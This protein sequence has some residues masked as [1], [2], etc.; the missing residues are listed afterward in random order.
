MAVVLKV[1]P[2]IGSFNLEHYTEL[3]QTVWAGGA[4]D[5]EAGIGELQSRILACRWMTWEFLKLCMETFVVRTLAREFRAQNLPWQE[6]MP[7]EEQP[8]DAPKLPWHGGAPVKESVVRDFVHEVFAQKV[9]LGIRY[10][11]ELDDCELTEDEW[12]IRKE[13]IQKFRV[14]KANLKACG[15]EEEE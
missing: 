2:S 9:H 5:T 6:G 11:W 15:E 1:F 14:Q 8:Y 13:D 7:P 3:S 12:R 4:T 10:E